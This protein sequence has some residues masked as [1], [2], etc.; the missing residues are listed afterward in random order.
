MKLRIVKT[1]FFILIG[2]LGM[3][4]ITLAQR[5]GDQDPLKAYTT[6]KSPG[7][8][9]AKQVDRRPE[10]TPKYRYVVTDNGKEKVSV[11]DGYRVMFGYSDLGYYFANVK[12]EQSE[13]SSYARDKQAV[14]GE[15]KY[16]ST[17]KQATGN[18]FS[19][20]SVLNGF[21]HYGLD[22]DQID[23]GGT[24]GTH[25]LL[26]D[27]DHLIVTVYFLNQDD[28]GRGKTMANRRRFQ[29]LDEYLRI[30]EEFLSKYS[31]CLRGIAQATAQSSRP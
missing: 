23:V 3:A 10:S 27:D 28:K 16:L 14:V 7:D 8:L 12:I 21:E 25:L 31:E 9:R 22:R 20:K 24:L 2:L 4:S 30:R 13:P 17:T 1:L 15:L 11:T 6:C 29:T 19:D 5:K 26:Y 18:V